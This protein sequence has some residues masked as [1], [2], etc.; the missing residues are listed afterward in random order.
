MVN[1]VNTLTIVE[2]VKIVKTAKTVKIVKTVQV[3]NAAKIVRRWF[4]GS[5]L[6]DTLAYRTCLH[7]H[8]NHDHYDSSF[9]TQTL[10][11]TLHIQYMAIRVYI[12]HFRTPHSTILSLFHLPPHLVGSPP[13]PPQTAQPPPNP[14]SPLSNPQPQITNLS[15]PHTIHTPTPHSLHCFS[16]QSLKLA[17]P[18]VAS[19]PANPLFPAHPRRGNNAE[20]TAEA[21]F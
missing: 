21:R 7:S 8:H 10:P 13:T 4:C 5:G 3:V 17:Q 12:H 11:L 20:A 14:N 2:I 6:R 16:P 15:L 1:V 9:L 18:D 19:R